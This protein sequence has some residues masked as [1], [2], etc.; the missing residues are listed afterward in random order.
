MRTLELS[1]NE[2]GVRLG[3]LCPA[4]SERILL[5]AY[6]NPSNFLFRIQQFD[7]AVQRVHDSSRR[8]HICHVVR[9]P[10]MLPKTKL[11]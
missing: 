9:C 10:P 3:S 2:R 11:Q 6:G 5:S 7:D 4:L 8:V 1:S